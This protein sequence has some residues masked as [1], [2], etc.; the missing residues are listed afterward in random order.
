MARNNQTQM[1][2]DLGELTQA[3]SFK[4]FDIKPKFCKKL[5]R[6]GLVA[7]DYDEVSISPEMELS[8]WV[9]NKITHLGKYPVFL[10]KDPV[11]INNP[12]LIEY[13][14]SI[15][16]SMELNGFVK[17]IKPII[18]QVKLLLILEK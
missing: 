10:G 2:I 12:K 11:S 16:C 4:R 18:G 6:A 15:D 3:N 14:R 9:N 5:L 1:L 8:I 17:V 13:N 7:Q